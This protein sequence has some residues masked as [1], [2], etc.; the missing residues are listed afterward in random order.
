MYPDEWERFLADPYAHRAPRAESYHD[1]SSRVLLGVLGSNAL[2]LP[3]RIEPCIF[4][5][6]RVRDDLLIIGHASVIRCLVSIATKQKR[7]LTV[8]YQARLPRWTSAYGSPRCG[9]R[10]RRPGG[11]HS[12]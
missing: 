8:S 3:V 12:G 2:M 6:E 1:L 10:A 9:N 4:E 7:R 11:S 5:L